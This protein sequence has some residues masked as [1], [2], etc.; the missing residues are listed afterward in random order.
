V[1]GAAIGLAGCYAT[2]FFSTL[3]VF[4]KPIANEF[5]WGRAQTAGTTVLSMLG[6]AVGSV[7]VGRLIDR[8][9]AA[10]TI[11]VS[12]VLLAT[13]VAVMSQISSQPGAL[14]ALSF[15][16]GL[17]GVATTPLGYLSVLPRLFDRRL[18]LALGLSMAGLGVGAVGMPVLAQHLVDLQGWRQAYVTLA[19][20][21][22]G[23]AAIA[24]LLMFAG[25]RQPQSYAVSAMQQDAV[26]S[27]DTLSQAVRQPRFWLLALIIFFVSMAALGFAVHGFAVFTDRGLSGEEAARIGGTAAI[28]VML[29]RLFGGAL[30]DHFS[31]SR[32]AATT[33]AMAG[34]GLWLVARDTSNAAL[35]L[36]FAGF[37]AN[38]A[39]GAEGDLIPFA[40]RRYFGN[41][42]MGAI[43]GCL[44]AIY[45]IGG[46]VGPI[47]LGVAFDKTGDYRSMLA[48]YSGMCAFAAVASLFLGAYKFVAH[49][50][51]VSD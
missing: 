12:S 5:G 29:G 38:F 27:G 37:L 6:M 46:V 16:I 45:A 13:L 44:F 43:F 21:A 1:I 23:T 32:V 4:L 30:M 24:W 3:S 19:C 47:V 15:A 11:A 8:F 33:F 40:V 18:G 7:I 41:R 42:A 36:T 20:V 31:A 49:A 9:G 25:V 35:L 34:V 17:V 2:L 22:L 48:V 14:A 26:L 51:V 28:G 10:K 50:R 39:I